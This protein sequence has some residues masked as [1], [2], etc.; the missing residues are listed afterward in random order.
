MAPMNKSPAPSP[1]AP[2]P[3]YSVGADHYLIAHE[4]AAVI[5][6]PSPNHGGAL[7]PT[8]VVLHCTGADGEEGS[9]A[10]LCDRAA[11][12]SAHLLIARTGQ[13]YQL[14][15]F[16]LCAWHAGG[17]VWRGNGRLNSTTI[18]IEF[19]NCA[20]VS[21]PYRTNSHRQLS[22]AQ[23]LRARHKHGGAVQAWERY[24]PAQIATGGQVCAALQRHYGL[25]PEVIGHEDADAKR[26]VDPGPAWDWTAFNLALAAARAA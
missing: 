14:V 15:P 3:H 18:G 13:I 5:R 25:T 4:A 20:F 10:W 11:K 23:V 9:L 12:A 22:E 2:R 16:N 8:F 19:A 7:R 21:A 26:R 1:T 17:A 6:R 24:S